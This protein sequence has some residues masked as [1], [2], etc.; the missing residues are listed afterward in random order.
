MKYD[1]LLL[2]SI[3][4]KLSFTILRIINKRKYI[5]SPLMSSR[6][7]AT[8]YSFFFALPSF[9]KTHNLRFCPHITSTTNGILLGSNYV[10]IFLFSSYIFCRY[11][12]KIEG[13]TLLKKDNIAERKGWKFFSSQNRWNRNSYFPLIAFVHVQL[14]LS[15][16]HVD[17]ACC[18]FRFRKSRE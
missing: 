7:A 17:S 12:F 14:F 13:T 5:S 15:F 4:F 2:N 8:T 18:A 9:E 16:Y 11:F 3:C 1:N 6:R 10:V